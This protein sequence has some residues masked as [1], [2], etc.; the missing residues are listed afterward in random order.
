MGS[1]PPYCKTKILQPRKSVCRLVSFFCHRMLI[2]AASATSRSAFRLERLVRVAT[3]IIVLCTGR[4]HLRVRRAFLIYH[5]LVIDMLLLLYLGV[6]QHSANK[7]AGSEDHDDLEIRSPYVNL[8]SLYS[9]TSLQSSKHDPIVNHARAFVQI[10][11]TE[12]HK[13]FPPYGLMRPTGDGMVPE[14]QRHLLVTPTVLINY[15]VFSPA[16]IGSR[17]R[18]LHSSE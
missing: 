4:A 12:P 18:P 8:A 14:Y 5:F 16:D 1:M 9:Q 2:A 11:S 6:H 7:T 17:F 13:V 3:T 15:L 10:S